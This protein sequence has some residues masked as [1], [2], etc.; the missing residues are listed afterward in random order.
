MDTP[1][2]GLPAPW[3]PEAVVAFVVHHRPWRHV[4]RHMV[5]LPRR[6]ASGAG[7]ESQCVFAANWQ[8]LGWLDL[9]RPLTAGASVPDLGAAESGRRKTAVA[10]MIGRAR[11]SSAPWTTSCCTR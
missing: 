10:E 8:Q 1:G 2:H 3:A 5:D 6:Q 7:Q 9:D 4:D 11:R